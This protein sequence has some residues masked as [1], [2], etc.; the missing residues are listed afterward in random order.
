M[1]KAKSRKKAG[2]EIAQTRDG[3]ANLVQRAGYGAGNSMSSGTYVPSEILSR[4]RIKLEWA[5]R[6]NWV[7]GVAID[8][9]AEDMTRAGIEISGDLEPGEVEDLQAAINRLGVWDA[10]LDTIK[11]GRLYGGSIAIMQV[12]GQRLDTPLRADTIGEGQFQGLAVYDRWMVQPDLTQFIP[13]GP[14][15][16]LPMFYDIVTS[17]DPASQGMKFGQK[18]HYSRVIRHLGIKLPAYQAMTEQYWGESIIERF[19]D[20]LLAFDTTTMGA[21]NLIDKA[22]LRL[23]GIEGLRDI[24]SVGGP[25]EENL[26]KMFTYVRQMQTNEGIT[27]LDKNDEYQTSTVTFSGLGDMILQFAQQVSGATGIPLVRLYGQS[28]AGLNSTGESDLRMYYDNI[29]A[30]QESTLR[31][32][33]E[34]L[35]DVVCRSALGKPLPNGTQFKFRPL[36]QTSDK[37]K[38]EIA[39][40][41]T[42]S[43]VG[44]H[45]AGIITTAAAMKELRQSSVE[46]GVFTN[47]TDED[48]DEAEAAPPP[49][50]PATVLPA[51]PNAPATEQ[52]APGMLSK[53]AAFIKKWVS[54]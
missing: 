29:N 38:A 48:I 3:F 17:Y 9:V 27:L 24:L 33:I 49:M 10:L 35:L 42:E 51:T 16:G 18:V 50:A 53:A 41:V 37:E 23:V 11:W 1:T 12:D 40:S 45:E 31:R 25:A 46:T 15:I 34:T 14:M 13:S 21:A 30:S 4:N 6:Q 52:A 47:I 36:W 7:V 32:P 54:A 2:Q 22:H 5:Y 26:I 8:A 44:A 28:P 43:V 19:Y 39:K 20:R